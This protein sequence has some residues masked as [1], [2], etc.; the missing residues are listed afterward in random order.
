MCTHLMSMYVD[1]LTRDVW[2]TEQFSLLK[3]YLNLGV[4]PKYPLCFIRFDFQP[5]LNSE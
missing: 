3:Q 4:K 1:R 5:V 2:Y